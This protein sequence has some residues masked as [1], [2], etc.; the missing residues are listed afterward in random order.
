MLFI[1][2]NDGNFITPDGN[3]LKSEDGGNRFVGFDLSTFLD[4]GY[5]ELGSKI[6]SLI[7]GGD[8][9]DKILTAEEMFGSWANL[10]SG[11]TNSYCQ[12][13]SDQTDPTSV[14]IGPGGYQALTVNGELAETWYINETNVSQGKEKIMIYKMDFSLEVCWG[15]TCEVVDI[16]PENDSK[17]EVLTIKV[18]REDGAYSKKGNQMILRT[19]RQAPFEGKG[20]ADKVCIHFI[21]G[22]SVIKNP[23]Y[24]ELLDDGYFC[25]TFVSTTY[26]ASGGDVDLPFGHLPEYGDD[27]GGSSGGGSSSG[28]GENL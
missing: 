6:W 20:D 2:N 17:G 26:S 10:Q 12:A 15:N 8:D 22:N 13:F 1:K 11:F 18:N 27:E 7:M 21:D 9:Y 5:L 23:I 24:D 4:I 14:V 3:F 16:Y 25:N 19:E 28:E